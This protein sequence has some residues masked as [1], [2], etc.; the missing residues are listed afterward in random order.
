LASDSREGASILAAVEAEAQSL[1]GAETVLDTRL[2]PYRVLRELG[3]GGMGTV[4]LA[5]RDDH[6]YEKLVAIK[7]IRHGMDTADVLDRFRHERQI[8]ANLD[9]PYIA[10][11]IDGGTAPDGRPFLV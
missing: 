5:A 3:R 11:L 4:Y 7:L 9:H 8:L 6:Q 10:R 2:G 1:F